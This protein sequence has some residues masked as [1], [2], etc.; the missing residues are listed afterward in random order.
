MENE[1]KRNIEFML[2]IGKMTTGHGTYPL[3]WKIIERLSNIFLRITFLLKG[4][5]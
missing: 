4:F 5:G 3:L 1:V 2:L